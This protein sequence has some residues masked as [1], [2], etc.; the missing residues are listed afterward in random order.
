MKSKTN[1]LLFLTL[2]A[3]IRCYLRSISVLM[4]SPFLVQ[5]PTLIQNFAKK[6]AGNH[7]VVGLNNFDAMESVVN[8]LRASKL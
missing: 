3:S 4:F 2:S 5:S 6:Q 8:D 7:K 1:D